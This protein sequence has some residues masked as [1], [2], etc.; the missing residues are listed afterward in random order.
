[1]SQGGERQ[2]IEYGRTLINPSLSRHPEVW[3]VSEDHLSLG[4]YVDWKDWER[5]RQRLIEARPTRE[6]FSLDGCDI[7]LG[8]VPFAVPCRGRAVGNGKGPY[9]EFILENQDL[10]IELL[11]ADVPGASPSWANV[12]VTLH[13]RF[14]LLKGDARFGYGLVHTIIAELGGH[15]QRAELSRVDIALDLPEIGMEAFLAPYRANNFIARARIKCTYKSAGNTIYF[16]KAGSQ[17]RACFYDKLAEAREKKK[18]DL[19]IKRRWGGKMPSCA[20][21]WS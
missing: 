8:R 12:R 6:H 13:G 20:G 11:I 18:I 5:T 16:G 10:G 17:I 1:M 14:F 3:P 7:P 2:G 19:M 4:Y 21:S 15:M 9:F